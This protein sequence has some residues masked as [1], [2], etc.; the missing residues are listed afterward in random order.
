M[1]TRDYLSLKRCKNPC[2]TSTDKSLETSYISNTGKSS[3]NP[4]RML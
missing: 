4:G 2:N 1:I 3:K